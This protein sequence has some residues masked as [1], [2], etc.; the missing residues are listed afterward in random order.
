MLGGIADES[1]GPGSSATS[2]FY[3]AA[4]VRRLR[5]DGA[6]LDVLLSHEPPLGA[7]E[8]IHPKY[9]GTGSPDVRALLRELGARYHFCGHYHEPGARLSGPD[10][11]HSY[12]LNAVGFTRSAKLNPGCIGVLRWASPSDHDFT[13][14]DAPWLAEYTRW[15]YR[16]M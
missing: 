13:I 12:E 3:T 9:A 16:G 2:P 4:E 14:L 5:A 11:T 7:A 1:G 15:T 8:G 6:K 10:G